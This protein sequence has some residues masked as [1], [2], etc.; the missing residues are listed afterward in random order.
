MI[1]SNN[2][3]YKFK[4]GE[5]MN[6]C[7]LE[8]DSVVDDDFEYDIDYENS[9]EQENSESRF[10]SSFYKEIEP[11]IKKCI[12]NYFADKKLND[13]RK[14]PLSILELPHYTDLIVKTTVSD[15]VN[16][17]YEIMEDNG[18]VLSKQSNLI[19]DDEIK[20]MVKLIEKISKWVPQ[21]FVG[22]MILM[23]IELVEG[24]EVW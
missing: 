8:F 18:F 11:I 15:G 9:L 24:M 4:F 21:E 13:G 17:A 16:K 2:V 22:G 20:Y 5:F 19:T 12:K 14:I 23:H 10:V 7:I 1:K 6:S 3:N